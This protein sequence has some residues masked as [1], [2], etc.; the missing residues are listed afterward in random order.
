MRGLCMR[1]GNRSGF[2]LLETVLAL[3][4]LGFIGVAFA[5]ALSVSF[6]STQISEEQV[7]GEN[8]ARTQ[9]EYIRDQ[10]YCFPASTPYTIPTDGGCVAAGG[11]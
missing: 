4:V 10:G 6:K 1:K 8:L 5:T 2:G 11:T 3:G 7:T 9:L